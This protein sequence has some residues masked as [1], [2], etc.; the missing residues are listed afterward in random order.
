M[1]K[2]LINPIKEQIE[3]LKKSIKEIKWYR[4]AVVTKL[5]Y[6]G[7]PMLGVMEKVTYPFIH[8]RE[9]KEHEGYMSLKGMR[10]IVKEHIEAM[11]ENTG[12]ID[13]K[14]EIFESVYN[15]MKKIL[16]LFISYAS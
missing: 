2:P 5:P 9:P 16:W 11:R 7:T 8:T 13:K 1:R 6:A 15:N 10:A 14:Y 12:V 4:Q 3:Q